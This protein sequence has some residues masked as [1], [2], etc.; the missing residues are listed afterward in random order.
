MVSP[1]NDATITGTTTT[2]K[3]TGS[4]VDLNDVLSFDESNKNKINKLKE[5]FNIF[6][7][8]NQ[9]RIAKETNQKVSQGNELM[10][11]NFSTKKINLFSFIN[12]KPDLALSPFTKN[13]LNTDKASINLINSNQSKIVHPVKQIPMSLSRIEKNLLDSKYDICKY[14]SSKGQNTK[15]TNLYNLSLSKTQNKIRKMINGL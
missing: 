11:N 7:I 12:K 9:S 10:Q 15:V 14:Y 5:D 6:K 13:I 1:T 4:D 2:L 3:W 8:K